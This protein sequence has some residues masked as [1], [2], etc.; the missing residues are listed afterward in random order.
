MNSNFQPARLDRNTGQ[1]ALDSSDGNINLDVESR[2][3]ERDRSDKNN[4]IMIMIYAY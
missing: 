2:R 4:N 3:F 1:S